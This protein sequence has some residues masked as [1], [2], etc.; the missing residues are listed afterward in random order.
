MAGRSDP[1]VGLV[2]CI[3]PYM[4]N[5]NSSLQTLLLLLFVGEKKTHAGGCC[6]G[7]AAAA[8]QSQTLTTGADDKWVEWD[9][10]INTVH[11]GL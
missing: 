3:I 7:D 9:Q 11:A 6:I 4:H 2:R 1:P 8:A 10:A 5:T